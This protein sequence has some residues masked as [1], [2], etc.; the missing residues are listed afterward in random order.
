M[1]ARRMARLLGERVFPKQAALVVER[2]RAAF[3]SSPFAVAFTPL[4]VACNG[5]PTTRRFGAGAEVCRFGCHDM[6]GVDA[7]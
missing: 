5:M 3:S 1:V 7:R 4:N 2:L 6:G